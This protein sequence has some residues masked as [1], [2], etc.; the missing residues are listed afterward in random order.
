MKCD[1][2]FRHYLEILEKFKRKDY[3][4]GL[5]DEEPKG[6][7]VYL[8]HDLDH[9]IEK[10]V[11][12]A[13]LER[14]VGAKATYCIRF[15]SPFDN[16]FNHKNRDA[17]QKIHSRGHTIGLHYEREAWNGVVE[18]EIARQLEILK[19]YFPIKDIVSFHRPQEDIFNKVFKGFVNTYEQK[20]FGDIRYLSDSTGTWR[21]GCPCKN[22]NR[23]KDKNY[24]FLTHP[25]WWGREEGNACKHLHNFFKE[26]M[27]N[28]EQDFYEDNPFYT[29]RL[30]MK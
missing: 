4:F 11:P 9:S 27:L 21:S 8:R 7:V 18:E 2:T 24:Q 30:E 28:D 20:F 17:I 1:F 22:L 16:L 26:R 14:S 25:V 29:D 13:D 6:K 23:I 12:I 3:Q 19:K 15:A 10:A 5:F